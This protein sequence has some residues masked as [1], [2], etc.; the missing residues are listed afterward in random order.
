[1]GSIWSST[2][3]KL[4]AVSHVTEDERPPIVTTPRDGSLGW[5]DSIP[6]RVP[7]PGTQ[8]ITVEAWGAPVGVN[9]MDVAAFSPGCTVTRAVPHATS[10]PLAAASFAMTDTRRFG[11]TGT[12]AM[13]AV[14]VFSPGTK[15]AVAVI[16]GAMSAAETLPLTCGVVAGIASAH[17]PPRTTVSASVPV[18]SVSGLAGPGAPHPAR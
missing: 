5:G 7:A 14:A 6:G 17:A 18:R 10:E 3:R 13:V 4:A 15:V 11:P 12:P 9:V 8:P 2:T 16:G 1:V